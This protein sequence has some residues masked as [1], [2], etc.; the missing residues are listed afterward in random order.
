MPWIMESPNA[1]DANAY[2]QK[3]IDKYA[4]E[5]ANGWTNW[6]DILFKTGSHQNYE[7]SAQGG[8]DKTKFY[9]S[10][11]Y[12]KQEGVTL[13]SGLERMTGNANI[14]HET[15]KFKIEASALLSTMHQNLVNEGTSY[16]SPLMAAVWTC[17]PSQV[18]YN[19]DGSFSTSFPL[20]S[21][22]NPL[23]SLTYNYDRNNLTRSYSTLAATYN[24]WDNLK[25]REKIAY[26]YTSETEDV[27][28]DKRT[29]DGESYNGLLQRIVTN[30]QTINTQT[31]LSY[32]KTFAT[33]HNVD[34]LLGFET[35]DFT[36][37]YNNVQGNDYPGYLYEVINAGTKSADSNKYGYRLSSFLGRL[38]YNY[39]DIYFR[40]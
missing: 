36:Q 35:E 15:E 26:D 40:F 30:L 3:N 10:L 8:T 1:T 16:A 33:K 12:T 2:A 18:P 24:I 27:L 39:N 37:A 11:S 21:G 32:I 4:A 6:R 9:T 38:N 5:P 13:G 28:W 7:L 34:A 17:S 29:G 20:T 14:S 25:L 22:T 19:A 31:Q 23:Q